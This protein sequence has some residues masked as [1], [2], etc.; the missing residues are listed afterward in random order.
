MLCAAVTAGAAGISRP[1]Q[2]DDVAGIPG[3]RGYSGDG[4]DALKARLGSAPH[5]RPH[6]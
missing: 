4:G 1:G 2:I 5:R 6:R 3:K